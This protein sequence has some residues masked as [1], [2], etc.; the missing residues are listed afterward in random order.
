MS[1]TGQKSSAV[2]LKD[3]GVP[4]A[5]QSCVC[6]TSNTAHEGPAKRVR[7]PAMGRNI[8]NTILR[9]FLGPLNK[10][11]KL[12]SV[13]GDQKK[14]NLV[15]STPAAS[16]PKGIPS[17]KSSSSLVSWKTMVARLATTRSSWSFAVVCRSAMFK[18][19]ALTRLL[20]SIPI[21]TPLMLVAIMAI[22]TMVVRMWTPHLLKASQREELTTTFFGSSRCLRLRCRQPRSHAVKSLIAPKPEIRENCCPNDGGTCPSCILRFGRRAFQQNIYILAVKTE[23]L[24]GP[25]FT[26]LNHNVHQKDQACI[27]GPWEVGNADETFL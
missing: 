22:E 9:Y 8:A 3:T 23:K 21:K 17:P 12:P 27:D 25:G 2:P 4:P 19:S 24:K 1:S 6:G 20:K 16:S 26:N 14:L 11:R 15:K 5:G 7:A 10:L 18:V 13:C